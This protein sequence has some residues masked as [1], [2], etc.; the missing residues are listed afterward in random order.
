MARFNFFI[1]LSFLAL[2]TV[3]MIQNAQI[4]VFRFLIWT[5]RLPQMAAILLLVV[6]GFVLGFVAAKAGKKKSK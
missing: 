5:V 4:L 6:I 2:L 1:V 3:L